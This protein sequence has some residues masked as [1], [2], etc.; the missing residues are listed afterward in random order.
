MGSPIV[1]TFGLIPDKEDK[2]FAK[3]IE[4][5]IKQLLANM[6]KDASSDHTFIENEIRTVVRKHVVR[7]KKRY[8][9]IIP[10]VFLI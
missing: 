6:K 4:E 7:T 5:Q 2:K 8:P 9:L 10:T 3:E 1:T